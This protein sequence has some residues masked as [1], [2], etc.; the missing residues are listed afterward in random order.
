MVAFAAGMVV[1]IG[2]FGDVG[3]F[4]ISYRPMKLTV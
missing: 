4:D 1:A 2:V 3:L